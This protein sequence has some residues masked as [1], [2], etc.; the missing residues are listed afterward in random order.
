MI[1]LH[2]LATQEVYPNVQSPARTVGSY[3][4]FSPLPLRAVIFCGTFC[5]VAPTTDFRCLV[6]YVV[7]T[8]LP[9]Y[10]G[11]ATEPTAWQI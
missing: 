2:G 8:F 5:R 3:P 10:V 6:L 9:A 7:R 1:G 4:A 11:G